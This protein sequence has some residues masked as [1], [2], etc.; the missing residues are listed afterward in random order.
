M[1]LQHIFISQLVNY[2]STLSI[3]KQSDAMTQPYT[4]ILTGSD[5]YSTITHGWK[6]I[7]GTCQL[8]I[9]N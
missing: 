3:S 6:H 4:T 7:L 1:F 2:S 5:T 8:E 9:Q